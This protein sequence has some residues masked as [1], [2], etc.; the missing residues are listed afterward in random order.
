MSE[1]SGSGPFSQFR[2]EE[3]ND[4][5]LFALKSVFGPYQKAS[6]WLGIAVYEPAG[7]GLTRFFCGQVR[8]GCLAKDLVL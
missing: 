8:W 7:R 2:I 1:E 6:A 5:R 4:R 3:R